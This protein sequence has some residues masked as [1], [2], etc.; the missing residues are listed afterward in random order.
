MM[1]TIYCLLLAAVICGYAVQENLSIEDLQK[2]KVGMSP[3]KVVEIMGD[4]DESME[5]DE[6]PMYFAYHIDDEK[7]VIDFE[8]GKVGK[9]YK[10]D[11]FVH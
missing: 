5:L 4:P 7:W 9:K 10:S 8:D 2:V 1:R 11:N 6:K 3:G